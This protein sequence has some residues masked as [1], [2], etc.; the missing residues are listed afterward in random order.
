VLHRTRTARCRYAHSTPGSDRSRL[1]ACRRVREPIAIAGPYQ[2]H[3]ARD[4]ERQSHNLLGRRVFRKIVGIVKRVFKVNFVGSLPDFRAD[5][6]D[7]LRGVKSPSHFRV[8]VRHLQ[9]S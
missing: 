4:G 9:H 5:T 7:Q 6:A 3:F 8:P 2:S 1:F